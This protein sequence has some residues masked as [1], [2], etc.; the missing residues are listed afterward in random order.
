MP[1]ARRWNVG[2]VRPVLG[3]G[4]GEVDEEREVNARIEVAERLNLEVREHIVH[5]AH[6]AERVG[7]ITMRATSR[8]SAVELETREHPGP[9]SRG[10][11]A[12]APRSS[13]ARWRG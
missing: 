4:V 12:V 2:I 7:T 11:E 3:Q 10:N 1:L 5:R 9:T 13:P 8:H 6:G